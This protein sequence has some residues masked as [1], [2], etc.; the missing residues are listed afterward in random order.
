MKP[1]ELAARPVNRRLALTLPL[2]LLASILSISGCGQK[3]AT[4]P[5]PDAEVDDTRQQLLAL[6]Q[7]YQAFHM[8]NKKGPANWDEAMSAGDVMAIEALRSKGCLFAWGTR[9]KDATV[10]ASNFLL[11]CLPEAKTDG[12]YVLLLDGKVLPAKPKGIDMLLEAQ[13]EIGVPK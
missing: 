4:T 5:E 10:G 8:I 3:M 6:G 9:Y 13:A 2:L 7:A 12:G 11:A 1:A